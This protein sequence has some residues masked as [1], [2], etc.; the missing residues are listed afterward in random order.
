MFSGNMEQRTLEKLLPKYVD[1][2][3]KRGCD[4]EVLFHPGF[5]ETDEQNEIP[6]NIRF[7]DFYLSKGRKREYAAVMS[8]K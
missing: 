1:Y 7:K 4:I 3:Q 2:A 6:G 5:V 8:L